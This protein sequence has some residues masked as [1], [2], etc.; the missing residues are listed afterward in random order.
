MSLLVS[1]IRESEVSGLRFAMERTALMEMLAERLPETAEGTL[2]VDAGVYDVQ[3]IPGSGARALWK[4]ACEI[5]ESTRKG[6]QL[7]A[8][9]ALRRGDAMP[10][11]PKELIYRYTSQRARSRSMAKTL[12]LRTPWL[13]VP[14]AGILIHAFPLDPD[15]PTLMDVTDPRF[16]ARALH[17]AW[18]PHRQKVLRVQ[19]APLSYTPSARV[20]LRYKV[21]S[22][23]K[24]TGEHQ[25][26]RFVGKLDHR[27][28][29]AR[30]FPGHW[31]VWK[32]LD[33]CVPMARP[34]GYLAV[35]RLSLQ[36]FVEG[37]RVSD[38]A[39]T[40][41]FQEHLCEAAR[42]I[43]RVHALRVPM[44]SRRGVEKEMSSVSRWTRIL[45]E[46]RPEYA[47]SIERL[48][49]R[50][51]GEL[52]DR[53]R[54]TSTVHA[55]FHL[56]NMLAG[57]GGVAL[58]DWDQVA[59]GDP[60][61]DVGR[62]L[63]SLRV[64]SLRVNGT[65]DGLDSAGEAFLDTYL[66]CSGEDECRAR[67]FESASLLIA[68]AGPFRLQRDGWERSAELMLE[69]AERT[70]DLS[71]TGPR[72]PGVHP[73]G[74]IRIP[75]REGGGWATD[76]TYAQALLVH[77]VHEVWG[78]DIELTECAPRLVREDHKRR[79][80]RWHLRGYRGDARW[81]GMLEG[82]G[83]PDSSGRGLLA[84]LQQASRIVRSHPEAL[85][86]PVPLGH[87]A[88]L[89]ML[90]FEPRGGDTLT[91][92][93]GS[94]REAAAMEAFAGG[95][96]RLNALDLGI[97]KERDTSRDVESLGSRIARLGAGHY[98]EGRRVEAAFARLAPRLRTTKEV[99][100]AVVRGLQPG[101]V[102][103]LGDAASVA[104]L[105]DVV[106]SDPRVALGDFLAQLHEAALRRGV[107]QS[108]PR[109]LKRAYAD[110]SGTDECDLTLFEAAGLLK[111]TYHHQLSKSGDTIAGHLLRLTEA[112]LE[113]DA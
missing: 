6:Y 110:A 89:S 22:E 45:M 44:L 71:L 31:A 99:R 52:A 106:V 93:L 12:P 65:V 14:S 107:G 67:L 39:G 42:S 5:P 87:L 95:L 69:E 90:V 97:E 112:L 59:H 36:D 98:P 46:L 70:L 82:I 84:R 108:A 2:V 37:T 53:M 29:P 79:Q 43:A 100:G 47:A 86:L 91:G 50:L 27:R 104:S 58:I 75:F 62:V 28:W 54:V 34:A 78:D 85:Q 103:V 21:E 73:D 25:V 18:R 48:R 33:G 51:G 16:M 10:E 111:R 8:V 1:T 72:V 101:W 13:S 11:P 68:A 17:R 66:R 55:D 26:H 57:D 30:L 4:I 19:V 61:V 24:D 96:S 102:R 63:A 23:H 40:P 105:L 20:A 109:I 81:R 80:V 74:K 64:S 38:L 7:I 15:L 41:E 88:P 32:A 49:G 94:R 92:L 76:A 56:A 83:Y 60:M 77:V 35:S 9:R 3:Y 113:V